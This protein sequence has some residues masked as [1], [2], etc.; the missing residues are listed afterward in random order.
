MRT[1]AVY[2]GGGPILSSLF[3]LVFGGG[4]FAASDGAGTVGLVEP[5]RR[6]ILMR[7][8]GYDEDVEGSTD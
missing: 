2:R 8:N 5:V 3:A 7:S 4:E 6:N 1:T